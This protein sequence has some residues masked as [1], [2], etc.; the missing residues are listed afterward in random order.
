M[1]SI[2]SKA[3]VLA[4]AT[5]AIVAAFYPVAVVAKVTALLFKQLEDAVTRPAPRGMFAGAN[6]LTPLIPT[7]FEAL[8]VVSRE[9][10]GF[11]PAVSRDSNA[12][13]AAVGQTVRVPIGESGALEDIVPGATP[14]NSGDTTPGYADVVISKSKAAPIRWNGEEQ[15]AVGTTGTYNKILAD[16]FADGMRK[17]VNAMEVDLA[18]AAKVGS[19]R[20]YGTAGTT[21][22]GTAGDLSDLAGVAKILDDNGA[23]VVGRQIVFNSA[24]IAN[25]RG[26]QSVLF[27]VNEAGSSDMLRNGMTDLLQNMAVRYSAGIAQHVKGTGASYVTSGATAAGVRDI[28][29]ATGTGTVL[30]GDVATFAADGVNKY[31]VGAGVAAPGTISLN[32]PGAQ[33]LIP[34]G[35]ALT[36][37]NSYTGNYAFS[38]NAIVLACRAPAV[39]EGG[40]SADDAMTITDP[41]T[42][43]SFEVRVYRQ[44][45]QV[46]FEI[47]MAWGT[48]VIKSEH[49]ATL[50]G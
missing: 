22:L 15:K 46:K 29:L 45:R 23:P 10:V 41:L 32:R 25:L 1:K 7:L 33:I 42:G 44:Y 30:A 31:I 38:R 12:E 13:R 27:K 9:M 37:G 11:I 17:I 47:C 8:N 2:L 36:V 35:N 48:A 40:D 43:L 6:V 50:L 26:K 39:P 16:Q 20:A 24:S 18:I 19:S 5:F 34:T 14:A 21:P 28:V 49:I 4:L 3:R